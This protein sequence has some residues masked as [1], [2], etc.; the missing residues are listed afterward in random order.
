MI[1]TNSKIFV[2]GHRGLAGSAIVRELQRKG[3]TNI[4]LRTRQELDLLNQE[5]VANF[6]QEEKPHY[7]V[8][9]AAKVGGI[10]ANNDFPADFIFENLSLQVNVINEAH[11][12]GVQN[13]LFLGSNCIYPKYCPQPIKEEYLLTGALEPTNEPYAIAK[14]AGVKMCD[15]YRRQYGRNYFSVMPINLYG[16]NDHYD[17][18]NNHV[19]PA[20]IKKA[21]DAKINNHPTYE[22]WGT[23]TPMREFMYIDD[24]AN[25]CVFLM[26]SDVS[27]PLINI[28]S[29]SDITIRELATIVAEVIG[30]EGQIVF[31]PSKPDGT[32][33]KLLD[34]SKLES[35][36][37]KPRI[38]L[39]EG[40][41]KTYVSTPFY[42][43]S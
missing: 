18:A 6:F 43:Q 28:G 15:S 30:F 7:V 16:P 42:K 24:L 11:K 34:A 2:A 17:L 39:E 25:A 33:R 27:E 5:Q 35:M 8:L 22:V 12:A 37:W 23:G 32:P 9:A 4:I 31:D 38:S 14:I 41:M 29:G 10:Q 36:G 20:L 21:H 26:E 40:I 13:L 1:D 19:L 3:Y